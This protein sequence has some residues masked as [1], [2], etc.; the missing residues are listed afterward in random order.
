MI[1]SLEYNTTII[2]ASITGIGLVLAVYSLVLPRYSE[3]IKKRAD[4][5]KKLNSQLEKKTNALL[6]DRTNSEIL[7]KIRELQKEIERFDELPIYL[8]KAGVLLPMA[9][10]LIASILAFA[11]MNIA[12][13]TNAGG[14]V[15]TA[16]L[17]PPLFS[18]GLVVFG[19]SGAAMFLDTSKIILED[20]N[21]IKNKLEGTER[22]TK[23]VIE[24][25]GLHDTLIIKK[26]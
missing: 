1:Y 3:I 11:D 26:R 12:D 25:I 9:A 24:N 15:N 8:R 23:E 14:F 13:S 22:K 17:I 5:L 19:V 21:K 10:F 20:F 6:E 4:K 18:I 2:V 16:I 7:Q